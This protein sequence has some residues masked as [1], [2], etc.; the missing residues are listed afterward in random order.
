MD[1]AVIGL[2]ALLAGAILGTGS[3]VFIQQRRGQSH[4]QLAEQ[5]ARRILEDART[6]AQ[7]MEIEAKDKI[8]KEQEE[9]ERNAR[10]RRIELD[11]E[12][13]RLQQRR[14]NLDIKH[15]KVEKREQ[16]MSKQQSVI[17]R[18]RN[19][20]D[21]LYAQRVEELERVAQMTPEEAREEL[22]RAVEENTRNE[23]VR[24]GRMV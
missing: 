15:D 1:I 23:M 24:R 18:R 19:D 21:K 2:L 5:E 14:E 16:N 11:R 3:Y 4:V 13:E 8:L 12:E 17:D 6:E 20:A 7:K 9:V 22:L 10:K